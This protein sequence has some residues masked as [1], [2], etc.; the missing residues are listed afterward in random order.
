MTDLKS[1]YLDEVCAAIS[2][3]PAMPWWAVGVL[4]GVAVLA[5]PATTTL[6]LTATVGGTLA[7]T[8]WLYKIYDTIRGRRPSEADEESAETSRKSDAAPAAERS[9]IDYAVLKVR[10][11]KLRAE[12]VTLREDAAERQGYMQGIVAAY[13]IALGFAAA[14][15]GRISS[16]TLLQIEEL[17]LGMTARLLPT[18]EHDRLIALAKNPPSVA[19]A[20]GIVKQLPTGMQ[21]FFV[22]VIEVAIAIGQHPP[23]YE[24]RIRT[25]LGQLHA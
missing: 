15:D 18:A 23:S 2:A 7:G 16:D 12:L 13:A 20:L 25:A 3:R 19:T 14:E 1:K 6:A 4:S 9:A 22:E 21:S 11:D 17:L 24:A 8:G 10:L 5:G